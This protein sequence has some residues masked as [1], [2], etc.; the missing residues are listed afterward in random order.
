MEVA[1]AGGPGR[2][3]FMYGCLGGGDSPEGIFM[4]GRWNPTTKAVMG[5]PFVYVP[6]RLAGSASVGVPASAHENHH[7]EQD[8]NDSGDQAHRG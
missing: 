6:S 3:V 2:G 7:A 1:Q 4:P 5:F 8:C